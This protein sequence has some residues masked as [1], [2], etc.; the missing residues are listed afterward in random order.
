L[1]IS[2]AWEAGLAG[3][4][5]I[6]WVWPYALGE[7]ALHHLTFLMLLE[8]LVIHATGFF[9]GLSGGPDGT[10]TS[11]QGWRNFRRSNAV[12]V[13]ALA[14]CYGVFGMA[15]SAM[16]GSLW[17][18]FALFF[19]ILPKL[20]NIFWKPLSGD[21]QFAAMANWGIMAALYLFSCLVTVTVKVPRL[22]VTPQA[23]VRQEFSVE[24]IWPEEPYRVM[25]MGVLY[26]GG[27]AVVNAVQEIV[28]YRRAA[29]G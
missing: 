1:L 4:F 15:F 25:A 21:A 10:E 26:F 22:G 17:P 29:R 7:T 5:L 28:A 23:I 8:F 3:A 27:L 16:Y 11:K 12:I 24:G 14:L 20:P 18:L 2:S 9:S 6:T 19:V 13:L